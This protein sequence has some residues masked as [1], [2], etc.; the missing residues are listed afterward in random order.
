MQRHRIRRHASD[1]NFI[2]RLLQHIQTGHT[3]NAVDVSGD[4]NLQNNRRTF[5][6]QNFLAQ[7]LRADFVVSN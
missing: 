1:Q 7:L 3:Q 5:G 2:D 6:N 4:D